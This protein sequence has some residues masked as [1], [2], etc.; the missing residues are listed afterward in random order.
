M[1]ATGKGGRRVVVTGIGVLSP[2][3]IGC[4]AFWQSIAEGRS[5]IARIEQLSYTAV[6]GNVAGEIKDFT[7]ATARKTYLKAQRKS[8]KVMCREIQLGVASAVLAL[9]SSGL[10]SQQVDRVRF[11]VDFGA[12]QMFSPIETLKEAC[13]VCVDEETGRFV[14][15]KW[16]PEGM[17][18]LEPLW[19][20]KYLPNMPACHI[21]IMADAQGPSNSLTHAEASGNLAMGEAARV[22]QRGSADVMIAGSTGAW[23]HEVKCLHAAL[24]DD[25]ANSEEPPERWCRPF[26]RNRTGQVVGE[27]ACSLIF[28]EESHARS[29]GA[30]IY[31]T[32]LGSGAS[33]VR[34]R[35]VVPKRSQAM[36]NAMRQAL[37]DAGLSPADIG[38]I[39]AH[40][41]GSPQGD[42]EEALAIHDVFGIHADQIPVTS[43][44]SYT[45]NSG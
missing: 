44:K 17:P 5:G 12:N 32:V 45:G 2:I 19:L 10:D 9:E 7:E 14:Y 13:R 39:H 28:E 27:A 33:C 20:L 6:P 30:T 3:G 37:A 23:I 18:R 36:A 41:T 11:G 38:H 22:I 34:E 15:Q 43:L 31:G 40:G 26:D 25:L 21:A 8:L 4:D 29:R 42:R 1:S 35:D 16:G 24:W